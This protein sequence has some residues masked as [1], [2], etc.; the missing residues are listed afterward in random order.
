MWEM[1][2]QVLSYGS[3]SGPVCEEGNVAQGENKELKFLLD[4]S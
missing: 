1:F 2:C 3:L 4:T